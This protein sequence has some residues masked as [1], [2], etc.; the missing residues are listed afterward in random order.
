MKTEILIEMINELTGLVSPVG[1]PITDAV[2]L[3]NLKQR[4]AITKQMLQ[5]I[6]DISLTSGEVGCYAVRFLYEVGIRSNI[7]DLIKPEYRYMAMDKD[8]TVC[9]YEDK[10]KLSDDGWF[11]TGIRL[12][13]FAIE[14]YWK[15]SLLERR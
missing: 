13:G 9:I 12:D 5:V 3:E 10:P 4:C 2:R 15:E 14:G 6:K 11:G 7:W 8:G 1:E